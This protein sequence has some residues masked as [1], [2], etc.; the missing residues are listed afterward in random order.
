MGRTSK[1]I[2]EEIGKPN[3]IDMT[4]YD[5]D[6][7]IYNDDPTKYIQVGIKDGKVV[8]VYGIGKDIEISPFYINQSIEEI[9]KLVTIKKTLSLSAQKN[10]YRFELTEDELSQRPL[11]AF[12]DV[13]AQLYF[14]KFTKK[15]SSIRLM[16]GEVLV[17][18]RPYELV[19]KGEL[20]SAKELTEQEWEAVEKGAS[21]QIFD[22]TNVI[23]LRHE[24]NPVNW[25]EETSKVAY[26]HSREMSEKDFFS[27][28]SPVQGGLAD[29]LAKGEVLYQLA[30]EN[31]AAQYVDGVA[32]VEGWLNS[33]GHRET[34]LNDE[35]THLGV[36]VYE[37]Y[38]T[39]N[40]IQTWE[41]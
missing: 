30:G 8:T 22:I 39:Q 26:K 36:G 6:W 14:D 16:D 2:E 13:Y 31:I 34:L 17:K 41:D 40:F 3:R 21:A 37:K 12:G 4:A 18:Q 10:S 38:Y 33:Q 23:R 19:Y 32:V 1:E 35:F 25:H 20:L 11:V 29:R 9:N 27:H 15:L 7:W 5:Y 24:L 28:D